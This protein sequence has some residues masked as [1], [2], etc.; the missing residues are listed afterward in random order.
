MKVDVKSFGLGLTLA[1]KNPHQTAYFHITDTLPNDVK[2]S[3][4]NLAAVIIDNG[5]TK[6]AAARTAEGDSVLVFDPKACCF[7]ALGA[8]QVS[9]EMH[10][11]DLTDSEG[12]SSN[13]WL[14]LCSLLGKNLPTKREQWGLASTTIS[15]RPRRKT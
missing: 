15:R 14:Q 9:F 5:W 3:V 13:E 12:G 10:E 7:C 11:I 1:K 4:L 8:L 2:K 6:D